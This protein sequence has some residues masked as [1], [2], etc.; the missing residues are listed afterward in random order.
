MKRFI[1][2]L[3][4]FSFVSYIYGQQDA[5]VYF[6]RLPAP[7][8]DPCNIDSTRLYFSQLD[9]VSIRLAKDIKA[10]EMEVDQYMKNHDQEMKAG[11]MKNPGLNL[12]PE[13]A[14]KMKQDN[15]NLSPEQK[16]QLANQ[17]MQQNMNASMQEVQKLKK[18]DK[19][20]DSVAAM[21][22]AKAY[23]TEKM[24]DQQP[25]QSKIEAEQLKSKSLADL[26]KEHFDL[27]TKLLAGGGK[28]TQLLDSL[29]KDADSAW[30]E[31]QRQIAP[32][33]AEMDTIM[34]QW[35]REPNKT[36][37][38]GQRVDAKVK[39]L[40][41]II[42]NRK[43]EYCPPLTERY[44]G[45]LK[46]MIYYLPRTFKDNDR[47]DELYIEITYRRT[48]IRM[49]DAA[50]GLSSLKAVKNFADLLSEVQKFKLVGKEGDKSEIGSE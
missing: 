21:R 8:A 31:L 39:A 41:E 28:Y 15:K 22:W 43:K 2:V 42:Y 29:Q 18:D 47:I 25:D 35:G 10:R 17:M 1:L 24:A 33:Q 20:V 5:I 14:A 7:M 48:G 46:D 44:T 9:T 16:K 37:A 4:S 30:T 49:P 6:Q 32:V 11:M 27:N 50:K 38:E 26:S 34:S 23:G 45:I 40:K 3:F 36:E 19:P 13:M 12:T